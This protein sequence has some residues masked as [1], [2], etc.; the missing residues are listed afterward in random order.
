MRHR[1][2]RRSPAG[3]KDNPD[4]TLARMQQR[5]AQAEQE[6]VW[7]A[8]RVVALEAVIGKL[9]TYPDIGTGAPAT[10][11]NEETEPAAPAQTFRTSIEALIAT[12]IPAEQAALIQARLDEYDLKQLYIKDRASR[13]GWLKTPRYNKE[14]RQAQ[15]AYRELRAE[16]GDDAYDRMLYALGRV[17]R[18]AVRDIM[19]NSTA[20]QYGLRAN[21]RIIEYDGQRVFTSQE[22]NTLGY[23]RGP[24]ARWCWCGCSGMNSNSISISQAGRSASGWHPAGNYPR[25]SH[26]WRKP[27]DRLRFMKGVYLSV[28]ND[29]GSGGNCTFNQPGDVGRGGPIGCLSLDAPESERSPEFAV[30]DAPATA[31]TKGLWIPWSQRHNAMNFMRMVGPEGLEPDDV[32]W[33]RPARASES[34]CHVM[35]LDCGLNPDRTLRGTGK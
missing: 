6:R 13:E 17:N 11:T 8:E 10:E 16:I 7:L 2:R 15:N 28:A 24:L 31:Y 19:Q 32:G 30:A 29:W 9:G 34:S 3:Y 23:P 25:I 1:E 26:S 27:W 18:V 21:D 20:E 22:L 4:D 33:G 35:T 5:L 14:L 12:G